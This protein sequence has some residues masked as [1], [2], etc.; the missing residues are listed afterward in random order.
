[1]ASAQGG[2]GGTCFGVSSETAE[3]NSCC[4][5][6]PADLTIH[7]LDGEDRLLSIQHLEGF[8]ISPDASVGRGHLCLATLPVIQYVH[9]NNKSVRKAITKADPKPAPTC[10]NTCQ[11]RVLACALSVTVVINT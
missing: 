4:R 10:R 5:T 8:F 2:N 1:M 11:V 6:M 9:A 3:A 7:P